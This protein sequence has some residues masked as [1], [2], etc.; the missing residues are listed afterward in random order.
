MSF[1][2]K[3]KLSILTASSLCILCFFFS[4]I[5]HLLY[6]D[7]IKHSDLN[8]LSDRML[9]SSEVFGRI[10]IFLCFLGLLIL[11]YYSGKKIVFSH[12]R[13]LPC[14]FY[15]ISILIMIL[16]LIPYNPISMTYIFNHVYIL[17]YILFWDIMHYIGIVLVIIFIFKTL[18][19]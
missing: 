11:I 9:Y 1:S 2:Q 7:E 14:K 16:Y 4:T 5:S 19:E 15:Y 17:N 6:D 3:E 8:I 13:Q 10:T 18:S 12:R